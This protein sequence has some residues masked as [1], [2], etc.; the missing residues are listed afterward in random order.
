MTNFRQDA[1]IVGDK[2]TATP[3]GD[4]MSES[5]TMS[6][7]NRVPMGDRVSVGNRMPTDDRMGNRASAGDRM[8]NRALVG[9]RMSES[10]TMSSSQY[11]DPSSVNYDAS[12]VWGPIHGWKVYIGFRWSLDRPE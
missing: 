3:P 2:I 6:V 10:G 5:G 12:M 8:G 7:G 9:E 11:I 1:P 4:K